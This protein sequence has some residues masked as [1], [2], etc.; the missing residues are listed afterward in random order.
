[1]IK[2]GIEVVLSQQITASLDDLLDEKC[3]KANVPGMALAIAQDGELIYEKYY[4]FRDMERQLPVTAKTIFGVASITK[5]LTALAIM[6]L[7]DSGKL[8][9]QDPVVRWLPEL[10]LPEGARRE[11]V[12]IHHLMTHTSGLPGMEAVNYA[13]A[14]SIRHDPDG[15]YL[16]DSLPD[17]PNYPKVET[18]MELMK[19]MGELD[20]ALLGP[21]GSR[22]NYSNEG[23]ALLQEII[24][25]AS[26]Q[27]YISYMA[28]HV[29]QPLEMGRSIFTT[30]DL[31]KEE[32]VT[33]L[34]AYKKDGSREVFLSPSWWDSGKLYSNGSLKSCMMDL[35]KYLEVYRL[36]GMVGNKR[37]ISEASIQKMSARQVTLPTG[38]GYGYG[39]QVES[40]QGIPLFGHGGSIKGV[41]SHVKV[42]KE[43]GLTVSVLVNLAE[44]QAAELAMAALTHILGVSE[45]VESG[46][47][48][49]E[50]APGQLGKFTG[51][52]QSAEGQKAGV[53]LDNGQ[54]YIQAQDDRFP[55]TPCAENLFFMPGGDKVK[56]F[57]DEKDEVTAMFKG[58]RV[59]PK[60]NGEA[61]K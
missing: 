50:M 17:S 45:P 35:M 7:E 48:V 49:I 16:S 42:A 25:R 12:T 30:A 3:I 8:S 32:N 21:P 44:V 60:V 40:M 38:E 51:Y 4:G 43:Q 9:V 46:C 2:G 27:A 36:D 29:L 37:I 26:G 31:E 1:M 34:Y 53:L 18:V 11:E 6:Q 41:S 33:E 54:L 10:R 19:A 56:F 28:A 20:Y 24:E 23:Y 55:L 15:E 22:F 58:V 39:L 14:K 13:R 5:S 59:I 57:L 61:G 52:Y 47:T